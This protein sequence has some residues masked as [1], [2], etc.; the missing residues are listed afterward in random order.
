MVSARHKNRNGMQTILLLFLINKVLL[1][2]TFQI[3][4][5]LLVIFQTIL[6]LTFHHFNI[7][8]AILTLIHISGVCFTIF[9]L[10]IF[11]IYLLT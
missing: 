5:I 2:I 4:I 6:Y 7:L 10:I 9:T 8:H 1:K 11:I 3:G